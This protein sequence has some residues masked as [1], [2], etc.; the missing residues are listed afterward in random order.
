MTPD[1][2][3]TF[4]I[5]AAITAAPWVLFIIAKLTMKDDTNDND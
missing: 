1:Q 2:W 4:T 5:A 3:V